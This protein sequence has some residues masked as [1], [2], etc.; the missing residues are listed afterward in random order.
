MR[1]QRKSTEGTSYVLNNEVKFR[2][3]IESFG[4]IGF[5]KVTGYAI[6]GNDLIHAPFITLEWAHGITLRW[7]DDFPILRD[8][9]KVIHAIARITL[10]LLQIQKHGV[11]SSQSQGDDLTDFYTGTSA[12][13]YITTRIKRKIER[14]ERHEYRGGDAEGCQKQLSFIE[15]YW[16]PDLDEA[17]H[18]L[19]HGDLSPNNIVVDE[20]F[21]L[22][23]YKADHISYIPD[24]YSL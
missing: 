19:V 4:I 14:A 6:E 23:R 8:R 16:V 20:E 15:K 9:N 10:D 3:A 12:K 22:K 11:Y 5:Q 24:T 13:D 18:V 17:P 7:K 1:I 2:K 21:N